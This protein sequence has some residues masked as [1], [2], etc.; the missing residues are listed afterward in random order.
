[1]YYKRKISDELSALIE[2]DGKLRWLFDFVKIREDLDFLIGKNKKT[3][4]I[5]IYRGLSRI[6]TMN[7]K[8]DSSIKIDG[9]DAY[10]CLCSDLYG[11]KRFE[12]LHFKDQLEL[13]LQKMEKDDKFNR[14]Y[15]NKK[16][17]YYQNQLSRRYGLHGQPEDEFVIIDKEA[18]IGYNNLFEK[19][20]EINKYLPKYQGLL[21]H[22]SNIDSKAFGKDLDKK[23]VGNELDFVALTKNG[24]ILLIEFKHGSNTSGIYLSPIQIGMYYDL[25]SGIDKDKLKRSIFN[26]LEQKQKIGLNCPTWKNPSSIGRIIPVLIVADYNERSTAKGKLDQVLDI[27]RKELGTDFLKDLKAYNYVPNLGLTNW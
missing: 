5:S 20:A 12:A 26:M 23:S 19:H 25:F 10:K 6:L 22:L 13:L 1:M 14:Y 8:D 3:E 9:A 16:E 11:V 21:K 17:G 2:E 24:D 18:V 15:N 27:S 4:W 7:F